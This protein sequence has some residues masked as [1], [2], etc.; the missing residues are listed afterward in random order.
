VASPLS[1]NLGNP[2]LYIYNEPEDKPEILTGGSVNNLKSESMSNEHLVAIRNLN[3]K[4]KIAI[5]R[6]IDKNDNEL[7]FAGNNACNYINYSSI[8][9]EEIHPSDL[10]SQ[11]PFAYTE[12]RKKLGG[13]II[14]KP[15]MT[16][17]K[18]QKITLE[19]G[20]YFFIELKLEEGSILTTQGHVKIYLTGLEL[21]KKA[22]MLGGD[23]SNRKPND[24]VI[25]AEYMEDVYGFNSDIN[26]VEVG[27]GA[28]V[29]GH[30]FAPREKVTLKSELGLGTRET[31]IYGSILAR[32]LVTDGG[33]YIKIFWEPYSSEDVVEVPGSWQEVR[34]R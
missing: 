12:Y 16:L 29:C 20:L 30:I 3:S 5:S 18:N 8:Y 23:T 27:P 9:L 31:K 22:Q 17:K 6:R 11:C 19:E 25:L 15:N 10:G 26:K 28:V 4:D 1:P 2:L 14:I 24:L 21:E 32:Q 13:R 7:L 33:G 34:S